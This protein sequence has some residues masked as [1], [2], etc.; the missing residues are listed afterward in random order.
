MGR[1]EKTRETR[2]VTLTSCCITSGI[3]A[4]R[5]ST[6]S[7]TDSNTPRGTG[8]CCKSPGARGQIGHGHGDANFSSFSTPPSLPT[9]T[10]SNCTPRSRKLCTT[11]SAS[12][13]S[14][15]SPSVMT[16][17]AF[18]TVK[19]AQPMRGLDSELWSSASS[20][21]AW[22][23]GGANFVSPAAGFM[24]C[25]LVMKSESTS[26]RGHMTSCLSSNRI[27]PR[28]TSGTSTLDA[29]CSTK[30]FARWKVPLSEKT[31][32]S[33]FVNIFEGFLSK[34]KDAELSMQMMT[35]R[36]AWRQGSKDTLT[37]GSVCASACA[38]QA[39]GSVC[40][41]VCA[42]HASGSVCAAA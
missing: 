28:R 9:F 32:P 38:L 40:A 34:Q 22:R 1:V 24:S 3:R 16:S 33:W 11:L 42:L 8:V 5:A 2:R 21:K 31:E 36:G 14:L 23:S 41:A 20:D 35:S 4:C 15:G 39:S 25:N 13:M 27:R 30:L 19:P 6:S 10:K 37:T 12:C 18:S 26:V 17:T 7:E 29:S